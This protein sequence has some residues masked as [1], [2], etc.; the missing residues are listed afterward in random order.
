IIIHPRGLPVSFVLV[1]FRGT[2]N[3]ARDFFRASVF[4]LLQ[5]QGEQSAAVRPKVIAFAV[6]LFEIVAV[7][8]T[9]LGEGINQVS[10]SRFI[11]RISAVILPG[12]QQ[13]RKL[14]AGLTVSPAI[15]LITGA[16][17]HG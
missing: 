17:G 11:D 3:Q 13:R 14:L 5:R 2:F 7:T 8:F 4:A 1:A 15:N 6:K 12:A 9:T 10:A 16:V